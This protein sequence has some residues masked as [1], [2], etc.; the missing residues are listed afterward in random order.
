MVSRILTIDGILN[1][2]VKGTISVT[3]LIIME[4]KWE[5]CDFLK[6]YPL[7]VYRQVWPLTTKSRLEASDTPDPKVNKAMVKRTY[8]FSYEVHECMGYVLGWVSKL[9][10]KKHATI[11]NSSL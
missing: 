7:S 4:L 8:E 11:F 3:W 2:V 1:W 10:R 9:V 5:Q 6:V